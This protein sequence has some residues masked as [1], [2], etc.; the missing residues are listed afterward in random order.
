MDENIFET[1][2]LPETYDVIAPDGSQ[3]R[4]LL[5]LGGGSMAHF[6]LPAGAVSRAV[7]HHSV[8]EIWFVLEGEG[9]IWRKSGGLEETSRMQTGTC[10]TI[11]KGSHFQFRSSGA[12]P[13]K[14]I[15]VTMPPWP[16][17]QEAYFVTGKWR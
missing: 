3:V 7:A 5:S 15:A 12:G 6:E 17:E 11:P 10:I 16:G 8:E 1:K 9:E 4:I 13:L 2:S 14:I